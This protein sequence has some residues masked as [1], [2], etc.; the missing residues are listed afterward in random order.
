MYQSL[1]WPGI[2]GDDPRGMLPRVDAKRSERLADPL[3]HGVRRDSE[4]G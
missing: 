1:I 3:V 4:L 2:L